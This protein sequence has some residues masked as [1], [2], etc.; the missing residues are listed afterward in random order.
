LLLRGL[1][2]VA[3]IPRWVVAALVL[4]SMVDEAS[5]FLPAGTFEAFRADLGLSYTQAGVVLSMAAFGSIAG[6]LVSVAAD[7]VSRRALA[8]G[9]A[10][11][12]AASMAWFGLSS[13][14]GG[15][16][17]ASFGH[18]FAATVMI[19]ATTV[20]L[21][22]AVEEHELRPFLARSNLFGVIGDL[23]GP[24][25]LGVVVSAGLSWRVAF[26]V[27]AAGVA[28]FA[29]VLAGAP[30][31]PPESGGSPL[32][33]VRDVIRDGRVWLIAALSL[34][35]VPF[36]EP[37]LGFLLALGEEVR[38][39]GPIALTVLALVS[40]GGGLA[41]YTV[42]ESRMRSIGDAVT[43]GAGGALMAAGAAFAGLVGWPGAPFVGGALVGVG[44]ALAWL[45]LEHRMLTLRPGQE[46]TT[47]AVVGAVESIGFL[48]PVVVG[49]IVDRLGLG[50]GLAAHG[51]FAVLIVFGAMSLRNRPADNVAP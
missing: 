23:S 25:L 21:A 28:L 39:L 45:A 3:R 11:A 48:I 20:A 46:G 18:G 7:H 50:V 35:A 38:G 1:P 44:L 43:M 16:V 40:V 37:F 14:F 36:D 30:L 2:A 27:V 34:L 24:I 17:V 31:P 22:D 12:L 19:D 42:I 29:A 26:L 49:A 9:G 4:P 15:L 32:G 10:L 47:R 51:V 41:A 5:G 13:G 8:A 33:V 6:S